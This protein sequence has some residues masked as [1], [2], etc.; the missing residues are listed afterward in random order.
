MAAPNQSKRLSDA[1]SLNGKK[2]QGICVSGFPLRS[3][4]ESKCCQP[5]SCFIKAAISALTVAVLG[6]A[7][8]SYLLFLLS[9]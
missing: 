3:T 7:V 4:G 6:K 8:R 2:L 9:C 1:S 5:M